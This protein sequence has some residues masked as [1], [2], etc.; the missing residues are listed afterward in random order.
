[1]VTEDNGRLVNSG[2][3]VFRIANLLIKMQAHNT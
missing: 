1:M 3:I 2:S